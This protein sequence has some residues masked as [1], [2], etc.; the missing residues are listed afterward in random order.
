PDVYRAGLPARVL[1]EVSRLLRLLPVLGAGRLSQ[2]CTDRIHPLSVQGH[3][4]NVVGIV[5]A[6]K[7]EARH[8]GPTQR[9]EHPLTVRADGTLLAVNGMG[10]PAAAAGAHALIKAGAGA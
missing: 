1:P 4:S 8:L 10:S 9:R 7:A 3:A 5:C 6:L 2:R